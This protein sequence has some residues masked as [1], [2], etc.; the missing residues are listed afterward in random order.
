MTLKHVSHP[1]IIIPYMLFFILAFIFELFLAGLFIFSIHLFHIY[2]YAPGGQYYIT[3]TILAAMI[4]I[5]V[6]LLIAT[7]KGHKNIF[8]KKKPRS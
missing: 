8:L 3:A 4:M 5:T 1:E 6:P 7:L 2:G